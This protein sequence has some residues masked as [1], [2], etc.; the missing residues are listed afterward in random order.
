MSKTDRPCQIPTE[1][2]SQNCQSIWPFQD[3]DYLLESIMVSPLVSNRVVW[4]VF[5]RERSIQVSNDIIQNIHYP[6]SF[7]SHSVNN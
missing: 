6:L 5:V 3:C 4:I 7:F 1:C 2:L